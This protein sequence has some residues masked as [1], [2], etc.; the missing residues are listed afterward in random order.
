MFQRQSNMHVLTI[1]GNAQQMYAQHLEFFMHTNRIGDVNL[2]LCP[3]I[4]E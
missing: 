4:M 2:K 1:T 3:K